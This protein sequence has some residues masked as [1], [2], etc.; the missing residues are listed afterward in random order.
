MP[1]A[2][3]HQ[4]G[5]GVRESTSASPVPVPHPRPGL[6]VSVVATHAAHAPT[7]AVGDSRMVKQGSTTRDVKVLKVADTAGSSHGLYP[8]SPRC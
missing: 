7:D 3:K 2:G 6:V 4:D 1:L 5:F 8:I